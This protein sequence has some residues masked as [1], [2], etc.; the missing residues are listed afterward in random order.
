MK[1]LKKEADGLR[2]DPSRLSYLP[3][4]LRQVGLSGSRSILQNSPED[5]IE[6]PEEDW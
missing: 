1:D 3:P 4:L 5:P 2:R 6:N